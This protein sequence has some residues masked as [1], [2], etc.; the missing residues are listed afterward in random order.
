MSQLIIKAP[1]K[2]NLTLNI[3]GIAPNGYH[4]LDMVMHTISLYDTVTIS[5]VDKNDITLHCPPGLPEDEKNIAFCA[6]KRLWTDSGRRHGADITLDKQIPTQ[7]GMGG[8]SADAAAVLHGLNDLWKLRL[9]ASDLRAIGLSLGS[10]VPFAVTGG[11]A[12]VRGVGE[13]VEPISGAKPLWFTL[14]KPA[15]G[16]GTAEAYRRYDKVGAGCR[17]QTE[18]F[19]D[20][21]MAGNIEGMARYS[22]NALEKAAV[23]LLPAVGELI[24]KMKATGT[25]F[26]E[27]TGSGAVVFAVFKTQ[28]DAEKA[29]EKLGSGY[30]TAVA[31]SYLP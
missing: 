26:C 4:T 29:K 7:A 25:G 10:D 6:A 20:A 12:R 9:S 14:A 24:A 30:W 15:H 19:I 28:L 22:G 11:T 16:V 21:L 17:P 31:C 5:T 23:D 13:L 2:L 8:G 1:A 18:K 27:M 3:T